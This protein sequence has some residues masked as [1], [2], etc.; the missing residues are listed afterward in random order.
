MNQDRVPVSSPLRSHQSGPLALDESFIRL[1]RVKTHHP[2]PA[3]SPVGVDPQSSQ[4]ASTT[5]RRHRSSSTSASLPPKDQEDMIPRPVCRR[6][7][8]LSAKAFA[9]QSR[10]GIMNLPPHPGCDC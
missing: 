7:W 3:K 4:E 9:G 2:L 5:T 8:K 1:S 10:L 6:P